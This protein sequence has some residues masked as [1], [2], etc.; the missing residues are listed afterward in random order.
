MD[1]FHALSDPNR[2]KIIESLAQ[3]GELSAAEICEQFPVSPQAI[4]QHLKVLREAGWVQVEK[5]AQQRIYRL[6][7]E[8]TLELEAWAQKIRLLWSQRFDALGEV[9][10]AEKEQ[11]NKKEN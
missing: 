6:N 3:E 9:I 11:L 4:S 2:R 8:T 5:R 10:Q 7:P 1:K